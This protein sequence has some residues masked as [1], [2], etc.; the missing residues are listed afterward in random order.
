MSSQQLKEEKGM[1]AKGEKVKAE[2]ARR[3]E[4]VMN[5]MVEDEKEAPGL[6]EERRV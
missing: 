1:E 3:K 6:G 4:V 5:T 2:K